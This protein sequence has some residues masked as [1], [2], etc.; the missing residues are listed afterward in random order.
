MIEQGWITGCAPRRL[1]RA[2]GGIAL[3]LTMGGALP[4]AL[5]Q[6]AA[7]AARPAPKLAL[8][9]F[10]Q[11]ERTRSAEISPDG[12]HFVTI[13]SKDG[14][15]CVMIHS[16]PLNSGK[17]ILYPP[18]DPQFEYLWARWA[19]DSHVLASELAVHDRGIQSESGTTWFAGHET[20]L[21][22]AA[23]DGSAFFN[24]IRPIKEKQTGS[25]IAHESADV[26]APIQDDVIDWLPNE[27]DR[28]L[29]SIADRPVRDR[30]ASVRKI[31]VTNGEYTYVKG[32]VDGIATWRTDRAGEVRLGFGYSRKS[33]VN[34]WFTYRNPATGQWRNMPDSPLASDRYEFAG[35]DSD[36]RYTFVLGPAAA[37][38]R[39]LL[40]WDLVEDRAADTVY[41]D[42]Q[43]EVEGIVYAPDH[44][45]QI[46]GVALG[47]RTIVYLEP[48]W[49]R[50]MESLQAALPGMRLD[51]TSVTRD[52]T[53][54]IVHAFSGT[55]PGV[56]Y[57][58][59][60]AKHELTAVDYARS[61]LKPEQLAPVRWIEYKARDGLPIHGLLTVPRGL[62]AKNLP[63]VLLPHGGP[64]AHDTLEFDWI[65]QFLANRGYAVLQPNFRGSTGYGIAFEH[66][67][68]RQWGRAMQDDLTDGARWLAQEGI[69]DPTRMAIVGASYGGYAALMG[70]IKTPDL[71]RCA[72]SL[73]GVSDLVALMTSDTGGFKDE[74]IARR[75][76]DPAADRAM[77]EAVSPVRHVDTIKV[78]VLLVHAKDDMRVNFDQSRRMQDALKAAGKSSD[79]VA[80]EKGDH[81][82]L[83]EAG[84]TR[85]LTALEEFLAANLRPQGTP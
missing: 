23:A 78:P 33:E 85:F 68:D 15:Y 59:N 47:D 50:R 13:S 7:P 46:I 80:I 51:V 11:L 14:R 2:A 48:T 8:K 10:A 29:V 52:G 83:N 44:S 79:L 43:Q 58:F 21:F 37:D 73:N 18:Y 34:R 56:Y 64:I 9:L 71:F 82:L 62:P 32:P 3:G 17:T 24:V 81:W 54:F 67:G 20:R 19:G 35:F 72:V 25:D 6:D 30:G 70:A 12:R 16:L 28:V 60:A 76:G 27:T 55:E 65:A 40:R 39:A 61:G 41:S 31:N 66:A 45:R 5:A 1:A 57:L 26:T 49:K 22:S 53:Q 75:I 42:P 74:E 4:V 36:P 38:R 84:R 69:A 77:L 63:A